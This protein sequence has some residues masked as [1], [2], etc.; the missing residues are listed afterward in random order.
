M[1]KEKLAQGVKSCQLLPCRERARSACGIVK[2]PRQIIPHRGRRIVMEIP[3]V[4]QDAREHQRHLASGKAEDS[5]ETGSRVA[6]G[7]KRLRREA[8]VA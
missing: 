4:I 5:D 8:L 7:A 1:P 2:K 6:L 3:R